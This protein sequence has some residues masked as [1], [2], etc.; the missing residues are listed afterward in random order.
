MFLYYS[1]E[2]VKGFRERVLRGDIRVLSSVVVYVVGVD[3]VV[4]YDVCGRGRKLDI[5][6]GVLFVW[7]IIFR[8]F[9]WIGLICF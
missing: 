9:F 6:G 7:F 2:V 4:V 3:V 8:K 1:L 5:S